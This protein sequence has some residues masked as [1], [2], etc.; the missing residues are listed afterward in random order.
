MSTALFDFPLPA[1][2]VLEIFEFLPVNDLKALSVCSKAY[3]AA[4][5][6]T[7]FREVRIS[8]DSLPA[9]LD[10]GSLAHIC[11][12]VR[13]ASFTRLEKSRFVE[14]VNRCRIYTNALSGGLFPLL[15]SLHVSLYVPLRFPR[16]EV[17]ML[18]AIFSRLA[19]AEFYNRLK[20]LYLQVLPQDVEKAITHEQLLKDTL[21]EEN[22]RF[23]DDRVECHGLGELE[24][25]EDEGQSVNALLAK[26]RPP[27]AL[28]ELLITADT[29][30]FR[31]PSIRHDLTF[32][33]W[34]VR[35]CAPNLRR[36]ELCMDKVG[37]PKN[38]PVLRRYLAMPDH[39]VFPRVTKLRLDV[40]SFKR[41]H[42]TDLAARFP[43]LE[44]LAVHVWS[45]YVIRY[46]RKIVVMQ[47]IVGFGKNLKKV[48]MPWPEEWQLTREN[49]YRWHLRKSVERWIAAG[50]TGLQ[51]VEFLL[52]IGE[53]DEDY[54]KFVVNGDGQVVEQKH[55]RR[56]MG[57]FPK[58]PA[59]KYV[60]SLFG[61][62]DEESLEHE[63]TEVND[64]E[65]EG[66]L[67]A[68]DEEEDLEAGWSDWAR[69][70]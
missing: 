70:D 37:T 38:T 58:V 51:E 52:K 14:T 61:K 3:R 31:A 59:L 17:H 40:S 20:I 55:G 28:E 9:F 30:R 25:D 19:T 13:H 10:G 39:L 29:V 1:E 33:E 69:E 63:E 21:D 65:Q 26:L 22:R 8:P 2:L 64:E 34:L 35:C 46:N 67:V 36:L 66:E 5:L 62:S 53:L 41:R 7:L 6:P 57:K 16:V 54:V 49:T 50:L 32:A 48:T 68:G 43:C 4:V 60:A 11:P 23:L 45:G 15:T 18:I 27:P 24:S 42:L 56:R 47:H 12:S 44:E